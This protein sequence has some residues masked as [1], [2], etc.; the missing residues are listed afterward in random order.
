MFRIKI[1]GITSVEDAQIVVAAGVDAIGLNF[2]P[3]SPR[4]VQPSV[5]AAIAAAV[6]RGIIRTGLFVNAPAVEILRLCDQV[7]L[8]L[9]QLHGDEPPGFLASL[10]GRPVMRAF[11]LGESGIAP[12]FDYLAECRRL[13]CLPR[14]VLLDAFRHGQYGG[15]GQTTDW[16]EAKRYRTDATC[17]P[18]VLAGGLTPDNVAAAID[19][20]RPVAVDTSSGVEVSPGK[21]SADAVKRFVAAAQAAFG[22]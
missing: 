8:D 11:R 19:A 2:Y 9:I 17:P 5:A 20:V 15:T 22:G 13:K 10:G 18:L 16:T 7:P 6:P 14:L 21:K 3:K 4:Y 1:C 12:V